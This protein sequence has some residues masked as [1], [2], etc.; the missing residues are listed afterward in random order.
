MVSGMSGSLSPQLTPN[1]AF[2][3]RSPALRQSARFA[4]YTGGA[5]AIERDT[6]TPTRQNLRARSQQ[7]FTANGRADAE[8]WPPRSSRVIASA[9]EA[10]HRS[11]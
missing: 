6:M 2:P 8:S 5:A 9:S 7:A 10:I 4:V 3:S 11:A 1:T